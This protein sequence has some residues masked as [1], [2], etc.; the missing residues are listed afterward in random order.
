[1]PELGIALGALLDEGIHRL[2]LSGVEE[3]RRQVLRIWADLTESSPADAFLR[4]DRPVDT[5]VAIRFQRAVERRSAGEPL[6]HVT[7]WVGFRRMVLRSDSRALI[8]RPET[9]GLIDLLLQ[10]VSTG[11]VADIGTG[12]GCISLSLA[13]EG[14]FTEVIGVDRSSEAIAL[15]RL[16]RE[17]TGVRV[18]LIQAD[19]CAPFRHGVLDALVAN[20][21]YLSAG[22]YD[23]L[24]PS[25]RVWEPVDALVSGEEGM[26]ATLRLLDEGRAALRPGGW[27]ALEVDSS[28]A[29]VAA[30]RACALGWDDVTV[31]MDLFGRERYLLARRSDTR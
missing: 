19:L 28:R 4:R 27:L 5:Q 20:P 6:A 31:H 18:T 29:A 11:R 24:E 14:G 22:E 2:R 25:V 3:P 8:P 1:M 15:A 7:G 12:S 16:N 21:P 30:A 26:D 17:L 23:L 9:E 10:R 13:L